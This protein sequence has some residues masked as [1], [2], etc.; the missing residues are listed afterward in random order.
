MQ[1]SN[2]NLTISSKCKVL[3]PPK[4]TYELVVATEY[5]DADGYENFILQFNANS[6]R[7]I[8]KLKDIVAY[9]NWY[10]ETYNS[11]D[12][13]LEITN[14]Y[15]TLVEK[16][17]DYFLDDFPSDPTADHQWKNSIESIKVF[18]YNECREKFYVDVEFGVNH[19]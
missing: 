7:D 14:E 17:D 5:G 19:D 4:N 13:K 18:Y 11:W 10:K 16:W 8:E 12:H 15:K 1:L 3:L 9:L 6:E 2:V